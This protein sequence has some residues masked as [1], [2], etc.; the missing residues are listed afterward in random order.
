MRLANCVTL[1]GKSTAL[2][3]AL[4][5]APAVDAQR[6]PVNTDGAE[7]KVTIYRDAKGVPHVFARTSAEI[8]FGAGYVEAQDRLAAMELARRGATGRRAEV[9]GKTAIESDKTARDRQLSSAELMRMYR[10]IPVEHQQMIQAF[11]D[12]VNRAIA[13]V[14]ADPEQKMPL[15]FIRWGIKPT[16]WSLI[17]Y[18][19]YIA[20]VPNGRDSYELQNLQFLNAMT[21]RY[22]EKIG[23]QIFDDV[24]PISD[25]D[26]PT[27]IPKGEDLA[28]P[29]P[30][31]VATPLPLQAG[32]VDLRS[33]R[34]IA[35]VPS[36][37]PK[38]ASRCLVVGPK[39]SASGHVLMMEATADGPEIHLN[40]G[41]FDSAGFSSSGWGPPFMG[42]GV[43]HGWLLTSGVAQ[44]NTIFA[45]RLNPANRYQYWF[46][47]A[48]QT[49]EHRIET[50]L[51]KGGEPITYEVA[52]TIHGP[53]VNWDAEHGVAYSH[54]FGLRGKELD[55]W[56]G[57]V[58]MARAKSL[59]DFE[60]KGVDRV[61]WN[62]GICY[63]GEDGQIAF[64]EAGNL[65]KL[66]P[67]ADPRL[68]TP[69]TGEYEWT[70]FLTPQ[71]RP[72]MLNPRQ[73]YIH[74]WNS[75]ATSWSMEGNDARIG[76]T[77]RTWLGN[78]LAASNNAITLLD[79]REFNRKIFNA[80]GAQDRTQTTPAFF[81]PYI[82]AAIAASDDPEVKQA[83]ELMLSY[84]GLYEDLDADH[85]Y[86]NPGLTLFR[87]WLNVAPGIVFGKDIDNWWSKVDEGRYLRYQ[88]SL[89]LRAF[90]G[91][92]AGAPLVFDYFHGR[93]RNAVLIET[94]KATVG[95]VKPQ[96]PGKPM[97][98]WRMPVF[99]K[100]YD[101][102][103][104]R[105]DRPELP[106]DDNPSNRLSAILRIGPTMA[107]H[108][109]GEGW[110]GLM[111]LNPDHPALYSV[112]DAGGQSLFVDPR[113][114]GNPHLSDQTMMHETNEL[115]KI[116]MNPDD[117]RAVA[118]STQVLEYRP[119]AK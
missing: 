94:I 47:G 102:A 39:K 88:T 12:G 105:A 82:R 13:E 45:E 77:F 22:G 46:K 3:A 16:P 98:E 97:T 113:G 63:G 74:S 54:R 93:D 10:A 112:V 64:W 86:D 28:P 108:N 49:M 107:P 78:Q 67:G 50:I 37:L 81:V 27:A 32:A 9:L 11:V 62:L 52:R 43:Q 59:S 87:A 68:P 106:D 96:F 35:T 17:D 111:E 29:R 40:G 116:V 4:F 34:H 44:A 58:E 76:A 30:I 15:E 99:W 60:T 19:A 57:I 73:G 85:Q 18:L 25:P 65:P 101:P 14:N 26:S 20:S 80:M 33:L 79:M 115:K 119:R 72:H 110:V 92:K 95:Q 90:Q 1:S 103:A 36:E 23:R 8:M 31:P 83:G 118:A 48:W 24:V 70:G 84:N 75:K 109:G 61:G 71:E 117:V 114:V 38:E 91:D 5:L 6:Q 7:Q 69:G 53:V 42:R 89:L 55:S 2:L 66:A 51:V 56:V 21:S 104:K 41:G 100:Y